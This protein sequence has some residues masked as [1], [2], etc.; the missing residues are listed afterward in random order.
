VPAPPPMALNFANIELVVQGLTDKVEAQSAMIMQLQAQL[1]H[2]AS[3]EH[4]AAANA[5]TESAMLEVQRKLRRMETALTLDDG[6]AGALQGD[7]SR[8]AELNDGDGDGADGDAD[9]GM[10]R[11]AE[12]RGGSIGAVVGANRRALAHLEKRLS[13]KA[14]AADIEAVQQRW[15][16]ALDIEMQQMR[17]GAV[18]RFEMERMEEA[19]AQLQAQV[20]GLSETVQRKVDGS[21]LARL[22]ASAAKVGSWGDWTRAVNE[23]LGELQSSATQARDGLQEH[24]SIASALSRELAGVRVE[25]EGKAGSDAVDEQA[26]ALQAQLQQLEVQLQEA[27]CARSPLLPNPVCPV[28][29]QPIPPTLSHTTPAVHVLPLL[30]AAGSQRETA[31][32]DCGIAEASRVADEALAVLE[33]R[34]LKSVAD[35]Q[36][37]LLKR[38][39]LDQLATKADAAACDQILLGYRAELNGKAEASSVSRVARDV[40]ELSRACATL[41]KHVGVATRFIDWFAE[42]GAAYEHNF[43]LVEQQLGKLGEASAARAGSG[44]RQPFDPQ[45]RMM[46]GR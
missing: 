12:P 32:R 8:G 42:R 33:E 41:E 45:I 21:E 25:L 27:W 28:P 46:G 2:H 1:K 44:Q 6:A 4:V 3:A 15:A 38:A 35:L 43:S 11:A 29:H 26:Q 14:G 23:Q 40:G 24:V 9:A 36:R 34:V 30:C 39:T 37:G 31:D 22:E 7:A 19:Q 18:G 5:R 13:H 20:K 17:D 16:A 10:W